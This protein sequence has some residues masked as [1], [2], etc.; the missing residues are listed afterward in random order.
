MKVKKRKLKRIWQVHK[1]EP[2]ILIKFKC[3][4]M[5]GS[6]LTSSDDSIEYC[7]WLC[8]V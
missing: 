4:T 6:S 7:H 8:K 3:C 2:F 1:I 5:I